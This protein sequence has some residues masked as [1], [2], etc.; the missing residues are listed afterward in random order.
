MTLAKGNIKLLCMEWWWFE[1]RVQWLKR[2]DWLSKQDF[3][4]KMRSKKMKADSHSISVGMSQLFLS[5]RMDKLLEGSGGRQSI[6]GP[7]WPLSW[8]CLLFL[9]MLL[10][11]LLLCIF[12]MMFDW[13]L[14]LLFQFLLK[15]LIQTLHFMALLFGTPFVVGS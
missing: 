3:V 7:I 10:H 14:N 11:V 6:L 5:M 12:L 9:L 13:L 1:I 2:R 8:I 15:T 4:L